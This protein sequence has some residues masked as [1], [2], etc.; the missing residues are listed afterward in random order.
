MA[1]DNAT[2]VYI[3]AAV[4]AILGVL[5]LTRKEKKV[6]GQNK[7]LVG[8]IPLIIGVG[9]VLAQQGMLA[10]YGISP[11]SA[12]SAGGVVYVNNQPA[13]SGG[14]IT[15]YQPTATFVTKDK[16][17]TVEVSGT[18]WYKRGSQPATETAISNTNPGESISYWVDNAT[19]WVTPATGVAGSG[20]TAFK[21]DAFANGAASVTAYDLV[22]R[23]SVSNSAYNTSMGANDQ[24]NI[25]ITYQGTAKASAMPFGGVFVV[26]ANSTIASITCTGDDLLASNPFHLTY[27]V[28]ATS[29][30]Y[31]TFAVGPTIDD[32][33][34]SVRKITCQFNNGASAAGADS[35]YYFK[36]IPANYYI[37][38]A[39]NIEFDT[40]KFA[41]A[42]TTRVG[43]TINQPNMTAYW[44]A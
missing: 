42:E 27:T 9:L 26:E 34:G 20:V 2:I 24:A 38:D 16:Y 33:T 32:G 25:E 31:R 14:S 11:F 21:A 43:S 39:G 17:S 29:H 12:A 6:M 10:D 23:Q 4:L 5:A 15:T 19:Y 40:E 28:S 22:N 44:A 37:S 36:F 30:T 41:D 7:I 35:A 1:L 13:S 3:A 18:D 8:L